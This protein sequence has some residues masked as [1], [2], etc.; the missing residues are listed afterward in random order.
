MQTKLDYLD[1]KVNTIT[2]PLLDVSINVTISEYED[3]ANIDPNRYC[4]TSYFEYEFNNVTVGD[5]G[6]LTEAVAIEYIKK[7]RAV[8]E[9]LAE[10]YKN[11]LNND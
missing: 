5:A 11:N 6:S 10:E 9:Y 4:P 2:Y 7:D 1:V 8:R 3:D